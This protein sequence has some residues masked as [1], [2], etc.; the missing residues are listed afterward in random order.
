MSREQIRHVRVPV[1]LFQGGDDMI[2]PLGD[3]EELA[4]I[5]GQAGVP[6][7]WH[8]VIPFANHAF[9]GREDVVVRRCTAW[10]DE[11]TT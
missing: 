9:S 7:V 11:L 5:A 6:D 2:V 3:G 1:A 4:A 8:E 10:L